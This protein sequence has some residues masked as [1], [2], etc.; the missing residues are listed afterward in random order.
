[1]HKKES[2]TIFDGKVSFIINKKHIFVMGIFIL[3]LFSIVIFSVS[4]GST[5]ISPFEVIKYTL[6]GGESE[7]SFIIDVL[8]MPRVILSL[9]VGIALGVAGFLLQSVVRNPLASPDII[10]ITGGAKVAAVACLTFF[11]W[12]DLVWLPSV[13]IIG[14]ALASFII[15][16]IAWKKGVTPMRLV[17]VGIGIEAIL[18]ALVTMLIVFSPSYSTSEAYIWLTGS[19]YGST[20]EDVYGLLPWIMIVIPLTLASVRKIA[21]QE[22]GDDLATSAGLDVQK[23]RLI[24]IVLT[25]ILAGSAVAF[26]GGI[27]FVGLIAP[28]IAKRI[29]TRSYSTLLVLS[30][31]IG[32]AIVML[33]DVVSRTLFLP[34]DLPVGVF[35]SAIGAPFF[36]FLLYK[37]HHM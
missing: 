12:I 1:M 28:H 31:C 35:V 15:Y 27:G 36:I 13:A 11:T 9:L 18:G 16:T 19:V 23:N 37:N 14:S 22:L 25:V 5:F 8:R 20:W 2:F 33:A 21:I 26:A 24:M 4:I 32:G 30:G 34:L 29:V 10:G 7:F 17:L 6:L 3:L